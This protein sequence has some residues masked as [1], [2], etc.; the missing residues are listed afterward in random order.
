MAG[1]QNHDLIVQAEAQSTENVP[2]QL[3]HRRPEIGAFPHKFEKNPRSSDD[4][5]EPPAPAP[6]S[7]G[8]APRAAKGVWGERWNRRKTLAVAKSVLS[9]F[10]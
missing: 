8:A 9:P 6:N 2:D 1:R 3:L 7:P 10:R 4:V 5:Q